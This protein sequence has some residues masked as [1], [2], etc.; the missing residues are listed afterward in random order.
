MQTQGWQIDC[1]YNQETAE[2]PQLFFSH[3][4]KVGDAYELAREVRR[5]LETL[6]VVLD[7]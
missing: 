1:L 7:D 2:D 6:N 4:Y 5:G 3:D